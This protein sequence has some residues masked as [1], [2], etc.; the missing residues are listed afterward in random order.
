MIRSATATWKGSGKEGQGH[1]TTAS[2]V[3]NQTQY[4]FTSRFADGIG[5]NP[6]ELVAAAHAGCFAM[7]LTFVLG[8]AG[9][10][11]TQIDATSRINLEKGAIINAHIVLNA[12][13]DGI[14]EAK[15]KECVDETFRDC[16][17]SNLLNT[18]KTIEYTLNA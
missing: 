6:E 16:L 18:E 12:K 11:A 8:T 15:F 3:L 14:D 4:N 2:T 5:T 7:K 9:F 13:V 1:L 17:I 10:T